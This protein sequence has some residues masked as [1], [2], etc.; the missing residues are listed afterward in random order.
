M[1]AHMQELR[2]QVQATQQREAQKK[3]R[4][5]ALALL[6]I[7]SAHIAGKILMLRG[8]TFWGRP[9]SLDSFRLGHGTPWQSWLHLSMRQYTQAEHACIPP[10]MP[11]WARQCMHCIG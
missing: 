9:M 10:C 4:P 2:R 11:A 3:A 6:C 1:L 8:C 5:T 7:M